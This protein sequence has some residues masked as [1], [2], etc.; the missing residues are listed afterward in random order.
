METDDW[1]RQL[2]CEFG[3]VPFER[4]RTSWKLR[5]LKFVEVAKS[6]T[7]PGRVQFRRVLGDGGGACLFA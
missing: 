2:Q 7:N 6:W 1:L 3:S 5:G 4:A